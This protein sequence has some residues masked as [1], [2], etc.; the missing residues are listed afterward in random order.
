[1]ETIVGFSSETHYDSINMHVVRKAHKAFFD[2][3]TFESVEENIKLVNKIVT[4]LKNDD[5]RWV[6]LHADTKYIIPQNTI[7]FKNKQNN[8]M[9][10]VEDFEGFYLANMNKLIKPHLVYVRTPTVEE[11]D[12]WTT[13]VDKR[14]HKK[15]QME[16][17]QTDI[18]NLVGDWNQMK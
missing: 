18:N 4:F 13:I 3:Q 17:V 16:K 9:C 11:D 12:G 2:I 10:H 8:M 15:K 14:K 6:E 7:S 5:I 1:M